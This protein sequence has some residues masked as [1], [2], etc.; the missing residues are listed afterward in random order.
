MDR[1]VGDVLWQEREAREA[2]AGEGVKDI[3]VKLKTSVLGPEDVTPQSEGKWQEH[4]HGMCLG[5]VSVTCMHN[6]SMTSPRCGQSPW[7]NTESYQ[8]Y[9]SKAIP[10]V[11]EIIK[12]EIRRI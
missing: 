1:E 10:M 9:A 11:C 5:Q 4:K 7:E 8:Q 6:Q 3:A 12:R 2:Y